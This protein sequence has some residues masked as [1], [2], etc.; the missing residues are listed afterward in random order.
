MED[1]LLRHTILEEVPANVE[2]KYTGDATT[3]SQ[4]PTE[5]SPALP[6]P[7]AERHHLGEQTNHKQI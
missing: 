5:A 2:V 6:M 4:G 7:T 1:T 3:S